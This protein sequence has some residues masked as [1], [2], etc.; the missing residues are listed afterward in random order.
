MKPPQLRVGQL[1]NAQNGNR[2]QMLA[3]GAYVGA[4]ARDHRKLL[5]GPA[6]SPFSTG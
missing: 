5:I 3:G 2:N 1:L 6:P 4:T